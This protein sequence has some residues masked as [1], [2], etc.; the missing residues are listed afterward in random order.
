MSLSVSRYQILCLSD[1][2]ASLGAQ[3]ARYWV[4]YASDISHPPH[5]ASSGQIQERR[6]VPGLGRMEE[7][8]QAS[9]GVN[10]QTFID[11]GGA[12]VVVVP[13]GLSALSDQLAREQWTQWHQEAERF[14]AAVPA[15]DLTL[16]SLMMRFLTH[17]CFAS[18]PSLKPGFWHRN[19]AIYLEGAVVSPEGSSHLPAVQLCG[20]SSPCVLSAKTPAH[21]TGVRNTQ[22]CSSGCAHRQFLAQSPLYKSKTQLNL[23]KTTASKSFLSGSYLQNNN[24]PLY[25]MTLGWTSWKQRGAKADVIQWNPFSWARRLALHFAC[26]K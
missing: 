3:F 8:T 4:R 22:N 23:K 24:P 15:S 18:E 14:R 20:T 25:I 16:T 11:F 1:E 2:R 9:S 21:C 13:G 17:E 19:W 7:M 26:V 6:D 12:A 5:T 10:Q